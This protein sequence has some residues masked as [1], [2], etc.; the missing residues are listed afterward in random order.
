ML[1][2]CDKFGTNH[3]ALAKHEISAMARVYLWGSELGVKVVAPMM[4]RV[5]CRIF[6]L[7]HTKVRYHSSGRE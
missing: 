5:A 7:P 1:R 3:N 6:P 4:K 2:I